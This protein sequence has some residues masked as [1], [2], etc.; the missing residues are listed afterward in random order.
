MLDFPSSPSNAQ[1]YTSPNG[2]SWIWDGAKWTSAAFTNVY[3]DNHYPNRIINGDMSVDQR[4]GG[5]L[6]AM[7][8]TGGWAIDRWRFGNASGVA[9]K[10]NIGSVAM[11]VPP[12]APLGFPFLYNL[13]F[14][15]TVAYPTPAA[16]DSILFFQTVEGINFNDA[17]WG[18]PL[19]QSVVVEFWASVGV[20]GTYAVG[21][22]NS[23]G[24]RSYVSTFTLTAGIWNKVRLTI[25]GD[26]GGAW[27]VAGSAGCVLLCF[28]LCCGSNFQTPT[29]NQWVAGNFHSA[30]GVVNALATTASG[31]SITGVALMVGAAAANAEP[32]FKKF[33]DNLADCQRYFVWPQTVAQFYQSP[34]AAFAWAPAYYPVNL[35]AAPTFVITN[36]GSVNLSSPQVL[37]VTALAAQVG[38]TAT[39]AGS[40]TINIKF[41]ADADF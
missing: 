10:G 37:V 23:A 36:N 7:P 34:S 28:P 33:S 40:V 25:P 4:N 20:S 26:T 24:T 8:T 31:M 13:G 9:S 39:A 41:T 38:G 17:Q 2:T 32:E 12:N 1:V 35:R 5:S 19:A 27:N 30:A 11:A 21:I 15:T 16:A 22:K 6:I 3:V 14:Q 18:T 29:P